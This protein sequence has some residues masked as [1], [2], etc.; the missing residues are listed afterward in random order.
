MNYIYY[1]GELYHY[2]VKGMKWGVR[3]KP[4]ILNRISGRIKK[5]RE[6]EKT[7]RD[8]LSAIQNRK[9]SGLSKIRDDSDLK[10][11]EYR[12]QS[13]AKRAGKIAA[14]MVTGRVLTDVLTGGI[15]NY[16]SMTKRDIARE[17][18]SIALKTT[19]QVAAKDALAKSASKRYDSEG[20]K[21]KKSGTLLTGTKEDMIENTVKT[22]TDMAP[23][24]AFLGRMKLSQVRAQQAKNEAAFKSWGQNILSEKAGVITLSDSE[25]K[26][27]N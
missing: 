13:L 20:K 11:F 12:N 19:A 2:G 27:L 21:I 18:A 22:V 5:S 16:A 25:W 8:K 3:K 24:F 10:R 9:R 1:N 14:R 23:V 6:N 7:Y 4:E 15:N 17:V 26:D